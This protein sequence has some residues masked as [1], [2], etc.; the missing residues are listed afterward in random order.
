[1]LYE[2]IRDS[3]TH[4]PEGLAL[5][6][7]DSSLSF[8]DLLGAIDAFSS[9]LGVKGLMMGTPVMLLLPNGPEFVVAVFAIA[10]LGGVCVPAN[11]AFKSSELSQ[12]ALSSEARLVITTPHLA[13]K[14]AELFKEIDPGCQFVTQVPT[15]PDPSLKSATARR[16]ISGDFLFQFTSGTAGQSKSVI[17][18]QEELAAEA[19]N[20]SGTLRLTLSDKVLGVVPLSHSYGFGNCLLVAMYSGATLVLLES[21]NRQQVTLA[22]TKK[23]V[24]IFPGVP[25]MFAMLA[26]SIS[27]DSMGLPGLRLAYS[28]GAPLEKTIFDNFL[29]KFNTPIRQHYGST[30]TGPVAID[31]SDAAISPVASVGR[32]VDNVVIRIMDEKTRKEVENGETG[33]IVI[34]S[35][36][37]VSGYSQDSDS[38]RDCFTKEGFWSGDLGRMDENG[39]LF[40]TGRKKLFINAGA[41]KINPCEIEDVISAHPKVV[42]SVVLGVQGAYGNE[43]IKAVIVGASDLTAEEIRRWC[44]ERLADFKVPRK[45]EFRDEIPRSPL[46]KIL[47]KEM[48]NT[49]ES[50]G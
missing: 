5:E 2:M 20:Y 45:I 19:A 11:P 15:A 43:I 48:L 28:A 17:R 6:T 38:S 30:E 34:S 27:V 16:P 50:G 18:S 4:N 1:M 12:Y 21:F 31:A 3:A 7:M 10:K 24:T 8:R 14:H 46:G 41:N 22:L 40:I 49:E 36:T 37:M 39:N 33:E 32:P 13:Q 42:E 35:A 47:R 26:E 9:Q 23:G 44:K 29:E 25:F